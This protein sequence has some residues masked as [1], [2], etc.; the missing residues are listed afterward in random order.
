MEKNTKIPKK[1]KLFIIILIILVLG[2]GGYL[3]YDK[4]YKNNPNYLSKIINNKKIKELEEKNI[5]LLTTYNKYTKKRDYLFV[6]RT[7]KATPYRYQDL[8]NL[9]YTLMNNKIE[10]Y[11]FICPEEY[12]N[13]LND[14]AKIGSDGE[15]LDAIKNFVHPYNSY[16]KIKFE[17]T[18]ENNKAKIKIIYRY[19]DELINKIETEVNNII[20][21][22]IKE[23]MTDVEK[24]KTIHDYII[25]IT[26]YD[27]VSDKE[28]KY[29]A[30][31]PLFGGIAAS[32]GYADLFSII[33]SKLNIDNFKVASSSHLWNAIEIDEEW[34]HIDLS[35]DD[36]IDKNDSN[37]NTIVY[38]YYLLNSIELLLKE[39]EEHLF[40]TK[41]YQELNDSIDIEEIDFPKNNDNNV[42]LEGL[43]HDIMS[44][45]EDNNDYENTNYKNIEY[46]QNEINL[47]IDCSK[48]TEEMGCQSYD[49]TINN[50]KILENNDSYTYLLVT[51]KH[52]IIQESKDFLATGNIY[53]FD[54]NGKKLKTIENTANEYV[55]IK[56]IDKIINS[57]EE[58]DR[59]NSRIKI[60]D[61]KLYF[62][63]DIGYGIAEFRYIDL[64]TNLEDKLIEKVYAF[65][66]Q[67]Q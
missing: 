9:V 14:F 16:S 6:D 2:M 53:I 8:L 60:S 46:Q 28:I 47:K 65:T 27:K 21:N 58:N 45:N 40:N 44:L 18:T 30:E 19:D 33:I 11:E 25:N 32:E 64:N 3:V 31:G 15:L 48:F 29:I 63:K 17:S 22:N 4:I 66:S 57:Y 55:L 10:T 23:E 35:W 61:N 7:T 62:L 50:K 41:I 67:Q 34:K 24:I 13:C 38:D 37:N 43:I 36:P 54:Y 52:I 51:S 56:N 42:L 20:K 59:K 12:E 39:K 5:K 49:L 26:K 1:V